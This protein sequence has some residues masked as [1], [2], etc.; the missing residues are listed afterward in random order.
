MTYTFALHNFYLYSINN[1]DNGC[2]FNFIY[3]CLK[4]EDYVKWR[5]PLFFRFITALVDENVDIRK[6][7]RSNDFLI[8][9]LCDQSAIA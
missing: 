6:F 4:K 7:G 2:F 9:V 1:I 3:F 5:G 8:L